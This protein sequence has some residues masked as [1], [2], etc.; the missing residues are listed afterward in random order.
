[1]EVKNNGLDEFLTKEKTEEKEKE[2]E[3]ER[4]RKLKERK[5]FSEQDI[6]FQ[7]LGEFLCFIIAYAGKAYAEDKDF[8]D[9]YAKLQKDI[10]ELKQDDMLKKF[11]KELE[12]KGM[13]EVPVKDKIMHFELNKEDK[14]VDLQVL[15][16]ERKVLA[17]KQFPIPENLL[18]K[19]KEEK[20]TPVKHNKAEDKNDP[21]NKDITEKNPWEKEEPNPWDKSDSTDNSIDENDPWAE[22]LQ[23][24][25]ENENAIEHE[26]DR[27]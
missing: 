11:A 18:E 15:N 5:E 12:E 13:V 16:Q 9:S 21:W 24:D 7:D 17:E 23:N 26:L 19:S 8:R 1:M 3:K 4:E 6:K 14:V 20:E 22:K 10:E 27:D 25:K 2:F